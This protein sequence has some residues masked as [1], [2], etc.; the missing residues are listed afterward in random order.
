MNEE[1]ISARI[2]I[3]GPKQHHAFPEPIFLWCFKI[4]YRKIIF[5]KGHILCAKF[6]EE[7]SEYF[8]QKSFLKGFL[9]EG[10]T[11][12]DPQQN[13]SIKGSLIS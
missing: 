1:D 13:I 8:R 11:S 7:I 4:F 3:K 2:Y 9:A 6:Y 5:L 10:F 12:K